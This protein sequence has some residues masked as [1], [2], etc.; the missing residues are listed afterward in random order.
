VANPKFRLV[1]GTGYYDLTT[2]IGPARYLVTR[3]D[4]PRDRVFQR[5]YLGGHMAY[6]HDPSHAAISA[7]VRAWVTGGAPG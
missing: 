1:I 5:Q 7:D 2:T 4:Y 6:I 3:S